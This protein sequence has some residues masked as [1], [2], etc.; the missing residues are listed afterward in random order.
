MLNVLAQ[1]I[2]FG[3][4]TGDMLVNGRPL[5]PSFQRRTGYVQQQDLHMAEST[6]REALR[7][8]ALLRQ[9]ESVPVQEKYEY[10]ETIME[11]LGMEDYADALIGEIGR[12]LNVEQRK[13]LSIGVELASKP[14]LLLFLDEPT[15]GLDSQSAWAIV[16]FLR[17]LANAGQSILCTIHQPSAT[18]FEQFDRLLL[19]KK[20]GQTVYFGDI[21]ENSSTIIDYFE[22]QGAPKCGHDENPA[23]YILECIGA[24][25]TAEVHEDWHEKWVNSELCRATTAEIEQL[26]EELRQRPTHNSTKE[27][28]SRYA[29]GYFTQLKAMVWRTQDFYWRAPSYVMAKLALNVISGLFIG[30]T[31]WDI[32]FSIAGVQNSMFAIFMAILVSI[33]LMN[34]TQPRAVLLRE[35]FEVRENASNTYHW[36]TL[37]LAQLIVEIPYTL[38][39]GTVFFNCYFWTTSF[40]RSAARGGYFYFVYGVLFELFFTTFGLAIAFFSPDAATAS[41]L[42]SLLFSMVLLFCGVLQP[43]S[44]MPSFWRFMYR[45]SPVTY[46]IQSLLGTVM[47]DKEVVCAE[48]E[49]NIFNPP[50][51][52]TCGD[53][54]GQFADTA[55]GYINNLNATSACQYCKWRVADV[56]LQTIDVNYDTTHWRNIGIICAYIVFNIGFIFFGFYVFRIMKW[57][58][59]KFGGK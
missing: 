54:A 53:Y 28:T 41:V 3:V 18:L 30:F 49:Y 55:G 29:V 33:A 8:A 57:K 21:G 10:V 16:T 6:V 24:G 38:F 25:A 58:M 32:K 56:Y 31:F 47:H 20:G 9:P 46:I 36:S 51:G 2:D 34:Q 42:T 48:S 15:S 35:L 13:K 39:T 27:L 40:Y 59:P 22:S 26:Q 11:L 44:Q 37:P 1:R 17:K 45:T 14:S 4:I 50:P 5:D 52:M 7:F 23:E 12:G 43:L 19:L